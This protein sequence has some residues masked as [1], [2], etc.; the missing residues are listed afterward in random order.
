MLKFDIDRSN[1]TIAM[2]LYK[3]DWNI[4]FVIGG[5]S[6]INI[7]KENY[8]DTCFIQPLSFKYNGKQSV[9]IGNG[10]PHFQMTVKRILVFQF[11]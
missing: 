1:G 4:L 10:M 8:A 9:L 6:D 5:A 7:K 2:S 3:K 11:E